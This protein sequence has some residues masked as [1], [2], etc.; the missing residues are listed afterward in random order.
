MGRGGVHERGSHP[1]LVLAMPCCYNPLTA[2]RQENYIPR[3][4]LT[5]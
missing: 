5:I 1:H 3:R 2:I 4:V